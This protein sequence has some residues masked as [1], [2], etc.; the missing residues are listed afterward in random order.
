V[1]DESKQRFRWD[2]YLH[3]GGW[4]TTL[5]EFDNH[6]RYSVF[7]GSSCTRHPLSLVR[8]EYSSW[9]VPSKTSILLARSCAAMSHAQV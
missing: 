1:W 8:S 2:Q 7:N 9:G 4:S 3:P 5:I 6:Y